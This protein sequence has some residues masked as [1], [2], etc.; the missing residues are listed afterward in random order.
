MN[1]CVHITVFLHVCVDLVVY[2]CVYD[3]MCVCV[4]VCMWVCAGM[5]LCVCVCVTQVCFL[6]ICIPLLWPENTLCTSDRAQ[7]HIH[8]HTLTHTSTHMDTTAHT[9]LNYMNLSE[10]CGGSD[11]WCSQIWCSG[12][13]KREQLCSTWSSKE[14]LLGLRNYLG[15][16]YE[17]SQTTITHT[18]ALIKCLHGM[19]TE[20][21]NR[22]WQLALQASWL[23]W[24]WL[25]IWVQFSL[26]KCKQSDA[27]IEKISGLWFN[28]QRADMLKQ[29]EIWC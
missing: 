26:L 25:I 18:S 24:S 9:P 10:V 8:I 5:C 22:K 7:T 17:K 29:S 11:T 16:M 14:I 20:M 13:T 12:L 21:L 28:A 23:L 1:W 2:T 19:Y 27:L 6:P 15:R 3:T 4:C